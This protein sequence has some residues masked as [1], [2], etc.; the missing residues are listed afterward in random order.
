MRDIIPKWL[1]FRLVKYY[2]LPR[3]IDNGDNPQTL[4]YDG[5]YIYTVGV[6]VNGGV[7]QS[8]CNGE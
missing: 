7:P 1:Y 3:T 2:D 5:I 4:A 8:H 6:S